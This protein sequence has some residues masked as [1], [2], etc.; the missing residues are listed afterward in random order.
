MSHPRTEQAMKALVIGRK[1]CLFANR[2]AGARALANGY[3]RVETATINAR[4][5]WASLH[6]VL[7]ERPHA[8]TVEPRE[9][10]A[11]GK[12]SAVSYTVINAARPS[13][14]RPDPN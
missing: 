7:T 2:P 1:Q 9:A 6:P 5:P 3:V 8:R 11:R 4:E 14:R 10:L 13:R 12:G